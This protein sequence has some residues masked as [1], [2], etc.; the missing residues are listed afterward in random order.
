MSTS[1]VRDAGRFR[2]IAWNAA[3]S[4][5]VAAFARTS[6]RPRHPRRTPLHHGGTAPHRW[7]SQRRRQSQPNIQ[8]VDVT[9]VIRGARQS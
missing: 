3:T 8:S 4:P 6:L 2:L 7:R 1:F 9:E 5:R